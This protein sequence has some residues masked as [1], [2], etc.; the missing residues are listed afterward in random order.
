MDGKVYVNDYADMCNKYLLLEKVYK[1]VKRVF[2]KLICLRK[3]CL[4]KES[5]RKYGK[6][7]EI[8]RHCN[9]VLERVL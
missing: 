1:K 6:V 3:C 8:K 5:M 9:L 7:W 2:I 4:R